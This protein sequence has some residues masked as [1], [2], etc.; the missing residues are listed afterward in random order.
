MTSGG[1][2]MS[3]PASVGNLNLLSKAWAFQLAERSS[4]FKVLATELATAIKDACVLTE[5]SIEYDPK[6]PVLQMPNTTE[7]HKLSQQYVIDVACTQEEYI[8]SAVR[9]SA[10]FGPGLHCIATLKRR[11]APPTFWGALKFWAQTDVLF[12]LEYIFEK[13][14]V[15]DSP[16]SI[17][18]VFASAQPI[19]ARVLVRE[20]VL[21]KGFLQ[22]PRFSKL[23]GP[24]LAMSGN[25]KL[26]TV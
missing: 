19:V 3:D 1:I 12:I 15:D 6:Y 26:Q 21:K 13:R 17:D 9:P 11:D 5:G 4:R 23:L 18:T 7:R 2:T 14:E 8:R 16:K 10:T 25:K 20:E 24:A 22:S